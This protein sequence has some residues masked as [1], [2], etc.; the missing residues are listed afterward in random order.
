MLS[1]YQIE[2]IEQTREEK[3]EN[4]RERRE[5]INAEFERETLAFISSN[6]SFSFSPEK[7]LKQNNGNQM[8]R[9]ILV[10]F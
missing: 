4:R 2:A 7:C 1:S 8:D 3:K 6:I 5:I 10:K 9:S